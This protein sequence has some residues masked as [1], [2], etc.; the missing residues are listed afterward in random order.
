M[1]GLLLAGG[2]SS[3]MGQPKSLISYHGKPHYQYA[4]ELLSIYCE[5]VFIS[6][7]QEQEAWFEG[8]ETI[9]DSA[10]YGEIGLLSGVLSAFDVSLSE[11]LRD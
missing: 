2:H 8:Y 4:A 5:Q 1:N 9:P 7:R 3:R 11:S 10:K 6:C